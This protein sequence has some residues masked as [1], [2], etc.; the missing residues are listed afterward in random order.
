MTIFP[1]MNTPK[2]GGPEIEPHIPILGS[3][4]MMSREDSLNKFRF[5]PM[6][7]IV[8][9]VDRVITKNYYHQCVSLLMDRK[10][11]AWLNPRWKRTRKENR[12]HFFRLLERTC[13]V[14]EIGTSRRVWGATFLGLLERWMQHVF[15]G[16]YRPSRRV[17]GALAADY[18][19]SKS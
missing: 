13:F 9:K 10:K 4:Q 1:F 11:K 18:S 17:L 7:D 8:A 16:R 3:I 2:F 6:D 5:A 12:S 15:K 19:S 14:A